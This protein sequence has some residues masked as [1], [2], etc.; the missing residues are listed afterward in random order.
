MRTTASRFR[1]MM[2][3]RNQS[4]REKSAELLYMFIKELSLYFDNDIKNVVSKIQRGQSLNL[5][6]L[7]MQLC[8]EYIGRTVNA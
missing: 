5:Q 1:S 7:K 6:K 2:Q 4:D 3:G 8:Q